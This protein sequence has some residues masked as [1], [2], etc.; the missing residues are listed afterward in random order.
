MKIAYLHGLEST[1]SEINP[2]ISWIREY[3]KEAYL[4]T[5]NYRDA[6]QVNTIIEKLKSNPP[7]I[8]VGSSMGGY[9]AY[10]LGSSLD[11]QTVLFNPA[12][13]NRSIELDVKSI[14]LNKNKN[15]VYLGKSDTVINGQDV[16]KYFNTQRNSSFNY[17]YYEGSHRVP[18]D[19]FIA[20]VEETVKL[21]T[22]E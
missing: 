2:K 1:I 5:I 15:N 22:I 9:L 4:P 8:I 20:A 6:K 21:I 12:V 18:V 14:K 19:V 3:F 11:I 10:L 17:A 16:I 7:D 13:V